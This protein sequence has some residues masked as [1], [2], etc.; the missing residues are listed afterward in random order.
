MFIQ[1][2]FI[3]QNIIQS[4]DVF[5]LNFKQSFYEHINVIILF[6]AWRKTRNCVQ[7]STPNTEHDQL[8]AFLDFNIIVPYGL[9]D[10]VNWKNVRQMYFEID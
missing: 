5:L 10:G 4:M 7:N 3:W 9:F 2:D 1:T 8:T 6:Y